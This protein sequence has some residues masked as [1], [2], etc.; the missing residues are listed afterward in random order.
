VPTQGIVADVPTR[1][2]R[3]EDGGEAEDDDVDHERP[4]FKASKQDSDL[5][6]AMLAAIDRLAVRAALTL[7]DKDGGVC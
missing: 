7:T 6:D 4:E 2:R 5:N 1:G 3:A